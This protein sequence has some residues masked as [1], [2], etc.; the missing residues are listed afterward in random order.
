MKRTLKQCKEIYTLA[1]FDDSSFKDA[2]FDTYFADCRYI[3]QRGKVVCMA[4]CID[5]F[6]KGKKGKYLYAVATHPKYRNK[7]YMSKLFGLIEEEFKADYDFLCLHPASEELAGL[8]EK[9]GFRKNLTNNTI[10]LNEKPSV[11][12]D[13]ASDLKRVREKLLS[14]N[15][16]EY[17]EEYLSLL[18]LYCNALCDDIDNPTKLCIEQFD[19]KKVESLCKGDFCGVYSSM[20]KSLNSNTLDGYYFGITLG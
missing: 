10:E 6:A 16:I 4:F 5:V 1:F 12:L 19:G 9:K 17:S 20:S 7:G 18:L 15:S 3:K 2:L 8:Y 13:N 11:L 14:K